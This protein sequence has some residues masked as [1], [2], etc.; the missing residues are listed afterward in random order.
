MAMSPEEQERFWRMEAKMDSIF[1]VIKGD[2][3]NGQPG[4]AERLNNIEGAQRLVNE[5]LRRLTYIAMG[6]GIGILIGGAIFGFLSWKQIAE[7]VK[8][9]K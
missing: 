4:F 6:I 3:L 5:K 2:P 1:N 7:V 8:F 9:V